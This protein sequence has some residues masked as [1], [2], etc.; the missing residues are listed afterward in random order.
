MLPLRPKSSTA[1]IPY[2]T[3]LLGLHILKSAWATILLYHGAILIIILRSNGFI[4]F[5][6]L[7]RGWSWKIGLSLTI[8]SALSGLSLYFLWPLVGIRSPELSEVLREYGLHG[9]SWLIFIIYYCIT[10]P[11][12]EEIFW[13]GHLS[14]PAR[15]PSAPD[16]LFAG[17]HIIVLILFLKPLAIAAVSIALVITAWIWRILA[18][19]FDG[20][21]IP[22]VSHLVAGISVMWFASIIL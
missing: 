6:R 7:F 17:Y 11:I 18:L 8:I 14:V 12:L 3:I 2:I 15:Y 4:L 22:F 19:K 1:L 10:T 20:L 16:I 21:A 9:P 5:K 13:R